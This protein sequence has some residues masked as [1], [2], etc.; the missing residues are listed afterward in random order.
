ML[1]N[2]Y[3]LIQVQVFMGHYQL[4]EMNKV[5]LFPEA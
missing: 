1:L 3:Y 4:F 5:L 2:I